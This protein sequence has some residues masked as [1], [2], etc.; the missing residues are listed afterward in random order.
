MLPYENNASALTNTKNTCSLSSDV[1]GELLNFSPAGSVCAL[2]HD[3][4]LTASHNQRNGICSVDLELV[5]PKRGAAFLVGL[6]VYH[7]PLNARTIK[8]HSKLHPQKL[9]SMYR[10]TETLLLDPSG[11]FECFMGS[12]DSTKRAFGRKSQFVWRNIR[13]QLLHHVHP[14]LSWAP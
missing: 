8:R 6:D 9:V 13:L 10:H 1:T 12:C 5:V 11:A 3:I 7:L 2:Q 4:M 14:A